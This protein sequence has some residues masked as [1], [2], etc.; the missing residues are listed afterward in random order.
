MSLGY[1]VA[2]ISS[3]ILG[4]LSSES[5]SLSELIPSFYLMSVGSSALPKLFI[6][7][8]LIVIPDIISCDASLSLTKLIHDLVLDPLSLSES[9][10]P[11]Y[12]V[13]FSFPPEPR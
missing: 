2:S 6:P 1:G 10:E 8:Y 4:I 11:F 5:L 9:P 7:G 13:D 12:Y 3:G